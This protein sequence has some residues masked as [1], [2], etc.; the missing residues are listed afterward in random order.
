MSLAPNPAPGPALHVPP[1]R[2]GVDVGGTKVLAGVVDHAGRVLHVVRRDTPQPG[3]TAREV[4]DVVVDAVLAVV[5]LAGDPPV[6][7]VGLAAAGFM[8]VERERV[9]FAPHLPWRGEPVRRSLA[10]RLGI[11]VAVDNDANCAGLAEVTYGAARGVASAL[12]IT[13]G[14]G[15]GGAWLLRGEVIRGANGMAGEFGHMC[16]V[17]DGV[18]CPCGQRGC[19]EQYCSGT[20]LARVLAARLEEETDR[21][22]G[23][24]RSSTSHRSAAS[25]DLTGPLITDAARQGDPIALAAFASVGDWLGRGVANLVA[26]LDPD[27]VVIGGGVSQAG[28]LL[29]APARAALAQSITGAGHRTLPPLVAAEL[30][31]EAGLIGAAVLASKGAERSRSS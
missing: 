2:I 7:G 31:A 16:V 12:M 3:A 14:T 11:G 20:A 29:L 8:D 9:L 5:A 10:D 24:R 6:A 25:E 22:Q 13:L 15:I 26:A 18:V 23:A 21:S 19:W 28:E 17:P 30:G 1:V 27:L 4:E